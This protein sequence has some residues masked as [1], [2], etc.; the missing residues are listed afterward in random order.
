MLLR[1]LTLMEMDV[2]T[3]QVICL[4]KFRILGSHNGKIALYERGKVILS[5]QNVGFGWKWKN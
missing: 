2:L 1:V 5:I 4:D 3:I